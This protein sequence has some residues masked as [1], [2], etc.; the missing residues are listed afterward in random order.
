MSGLALEIDTSAL[1]RSAARFSGVANTTLEYAWLRGLRGLARRVVGITPP[2]N[3]A[4]GRGPG[5]AIT[6]ADKAR[7]E[8]ALARDLGYIFEPV[9]EGGA[10]DLAGI[11]RR[12]FLA[13]KKPGKPLR[14]DLS[15]GNRYS[16]NVADLEKVYRDLRRKVGRLAGQW[17]SGVEALGIRSPGWVARH[18]SAD[19]R[20]RIVFGLLKYHFEMAATDVPEDVR[21]EMIRRIAYAERYAAASLEREMEAMILKAAGQSGF[22]TRQ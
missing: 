5:G 13:N 19:G 15:E 10:R 2:A 22:E 6:T 18:G 7:G 1:V 4:S 8:N 14:S 11:H 9:L 3:S 21:A 20:H 17:N 12:L 16:A